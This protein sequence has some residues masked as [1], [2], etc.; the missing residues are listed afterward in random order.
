MTKFDTAN[1]IVEAIITLVQK[2]GIPY[3]EA[4]LLYCETN[5][6]EIETVAEIIQKDPK[7]KASIQEEAD[8][9]HSIKKPYRT[10]RLPF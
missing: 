5:G 2:N 6:I 9:L 10:I 7:L 1:T 8:S 4:A 3:M